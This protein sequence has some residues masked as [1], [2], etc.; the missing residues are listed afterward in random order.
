MAS[1]R[2]TVRLSPRA[3]ATVKPQ[4]S[5]SQGSISQGGSATSRK[6]LLAAFRQ[7]AAD[8]EGGLLHQAEVHARQV[9]AHNAQRKKLRAG[10]DSNHGGK[11]REPGD[12]PSF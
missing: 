1:A 8:D 10:E 2:S 6:L 9:L 11:E 5:L 3:R 7:R 12:A 4:N